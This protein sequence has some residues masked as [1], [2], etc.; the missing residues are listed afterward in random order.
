MNIQDIKALIEALQASDM[1][2]FS[3]QKDGLKL[4]IEKHQIQTTQLIS[5]STPV[6][7]TVVVNAPIAIES[8]D[9]QPTISEN[10]ATLESEALSGN[11]IVAPLVGVFYG[12]PSPSSPSFVKVGDQ[13]K[14]GDV[15]C[16]IEAMKVMNEITSE[17][18]GK[19]LAVAATN[20][21]LVEYGQ[22]LILIG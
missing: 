12:S 5:G 20:E 2:S 18:D 21:T 16:I 15:L 17:F 7:R 22:N 10:E 14:K 13:V 3:Y 11:W 8:T 19:V 1:T 9:L 4:K 6:E